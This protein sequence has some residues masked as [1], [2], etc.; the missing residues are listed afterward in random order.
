MNNFTEFIT[1][2]APQAL[3]TVYALKSVSSIFDIGI[4]YIRPSFEGAKTVRVPYLYTGGMYNYVRANEPNTLNNVGGYMHFNGGSQ[5]D[6]YRR[7]NM[8]VGWEDFTLPYDRGVQVP[9]DY[10]SDEQLQRV[11]TGNFLREFYRTQVVTEIDTTVFSTIASYGNAAIGNMVSEN[12]T[13]DTD[14]VSE[15]NNAFAYLTNNGV[16]ETDQVII[17]SP[18]TMAFLQNNSKLI[19]YVDVRDE[20][21]GYNNRIWSYNGHEIKTIQQSR[22]ITNAQIGDGGVFPTAASNYINYM[23]VDKKA[24]TP[25]FMIQRAQMFDRNVVQNFDGYLF[26]FHLFYGVFVPMNKIPGLYMSIAN[27]QTINGITAPNSRSLSVVTIPG[28]TSGDYIIQSVFTNPAGMAGD[29]YYSTTALTIG[30]AAPSS[31]QL[32]V[33]GKSYNTSQTTLYFGLADPT[34]GNIINVSGAV[35]VNKHA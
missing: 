20:R 16:E 10:I 28:Q 19:H 33:P 8:Q 5:P 25:V 22:F 12:I 26:N 24:V 14:L 13:S 4:K 32:V 1:K 35:T 30:Q 9:I 3:D 2:Y 15:F 11:A 27:N 21:T 29:L 34:S 23:I 17:V 18:T 31:S 6:G 7:G